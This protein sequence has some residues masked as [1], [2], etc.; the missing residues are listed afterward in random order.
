M[1]TEKY[2]MMELRSLFNVIRRKK[3]EI[4]P[5]STH[6]CQITMMRGHIIAYL[7]LNRDRDVFQRDIEQEFDIRRP[8]ATKL[9]QSME[10][11]G[12]ITKLD[13]DYDARLKKIILTEKAICFQTAANEKFNALEQK[14]KQGLTREEIEMLFTVIEKIKK[15]F[16]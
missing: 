11:N 9:L 10:K 15:N 6:D 7:F 2:I 4:T 3:E 12:L 14:I 5:D 16:E 1:D 8:T 13:V